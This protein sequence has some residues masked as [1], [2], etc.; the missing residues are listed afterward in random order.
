MKDALQSNES[1]R[2]IGQLVILPSTFTGGPRYLHEKTQDAMTYVRHYGKPDLFI[3][4]TCNPNWIEIKENLHQNA[5]PQDRYDIVNRVFHLKLQKLL[6]L[7]KNKK[8][9]IFGPPRC[10]MYTVEWQKRG[11]PHVHLLLW[12]INKI[13]P[14]EIDSVISAELPNKEED[15][16]L[17]DIVKRHMVHGPC[18]PLNPNCTCMHEGKCTKNFPK[19]FQSY[20]STGEDGYPK[21]RR[22]S[23]EE[24][25]QIAIIKNFEIDN[26]W[27]VPYNSL[28]LKI[29]DAHINVELCSSVK[30]IKYVTKYI[31][32]GNDQATFSIKVSNEVEHYQSGR[33]I[34]SSEAVWRILSFDIHERSP[35]II[36]LAVHLENGQRVYF[37]ENNVN[38][39]INSPRDTTL[40]AFFKLCIEDDFAKTLTYDKIPSFY[41]WNKTTHKF[42]RRKKGET[43]ESHPGIKKTNTLGRI[44]VVHPNN[45]ECFYM[46]M[47]LHVVKGPTSFENLRTVQGI[48]YDTYQA[49]CK[50]MGLLEDDSHWK[51]TLSEAALCC[52]SSSLRYLFA[53]IIVFCHVS[54]ALILWNIYRENMA[55]DIL[56]RKRR[57]IASNDINYSQNIFDEALID[58]NKT[59]VSLSG[60]SI[61]YFGLPMLTGINFELNNIE[62]LRETSYDKSRLLKIVAEDERRMTLDQR[63][64]YDAVM[65]SLNRNEGKQFFLDAPGGTGKTFLINLLLAKVRSMGKVALAVA[66]SGIAATLLEGGRTAH[67][68]F[69]IPLKN[70]TDDL[71]SV[72]YISKQSNIAKLIRYCS[73]IVWDEA[74]MIHK[75][76]VETLDRTMRD[77]RSMDAPFGGC[78]ILFSGDFRQI[79]PVVTR[80]TRGDEINASLKRSYI[81]PKITVLQLKTNIRVLF[82]ETENTVFADLLLKIGNGQLPAINGEI[83][84]YN[85]NLCVLVNNLQELIDNVYPDIK[86]SSIK[87]LNWFKERSILSPTNEQ[88]DKVNNLIISKLDGQTRV[89]YSIDTILQSEEAV[90]YPIEFLNSL[91]PP[92]FP[93]HKLMLKVGI[94]IILLRNL[95]P[96]K[97]CNGTRL[98]IKELKSFLIECTILTGCGNGETV[99]IPRIP[100]I[101]SELPF[102]FKRLQ[103]PVKVC[104]SMTIN[105]AQGQTLN[106]A[107]I[108]LTVQCFSHGQLYVALSR[109][110][111]QQNLFVFSPRGK[112]INIV[113]KEIL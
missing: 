86:N 80:G 74:S 2:D 78:L 81:W 82:S 76:S 103:F 44:Y 5:V 110:T 7:I 99:F 94:P 10:Y 16:I 96:P 32:K 93:P 39:V 35:A 50:T 29:F 13:R 47:L 91:N 40:T 54:D 95:N 55:E 23:P 37:T 53:I 67:A 11:L 30:L 1:T 105:K 113:Y 41:T 97:L 104:F 9:Y 20:T 48:T 107:G 89:Y 58:L 34:C 62:Y 83:E 57:E 4:I 18:A 27:V 3:T 59:V 63:K 65:S 28:L 14:D 87:S 25:G 12:L 71:T 68:T 77:L 90:H 101:P 19:A 108:D 69:K 111:S 88:V 31:N 98:L 56:N 70:I 84:L 45:S 6:S 52:S 66:S 73:L 79:L 43:V 8:S 17:Y 24:G 85:S 42:E 46:R 61:Q 72:C 100:M 102:Q 38:D 36:H 21:Y 49:A 60:K 26:R 92:G 33:Y 22:L 109:A 75:T 106:V 64:V 15:P 112:A 51:N